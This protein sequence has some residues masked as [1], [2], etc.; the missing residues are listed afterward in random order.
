MDVT[1]SNHLSWT[2]WGIAVTLSKSQSNFWHF[3]IG[4]A[5]GIIVN[6]SLKNIKDQPW[7]KKKYGCH[8][9]RLNT[10]S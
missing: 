2:K 10:L 9:L 7:E 5:G 6:F 3:T 4:E 1:F 8:N